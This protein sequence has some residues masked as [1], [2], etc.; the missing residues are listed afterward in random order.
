MRLY[1]HPGSASSRKVLTLLAEKGASCELVV[2]D[3]ASGQQTSDAFRKLHPFGKIPVLEH[4]GIVLYETRAIL[5]YL[6]QA[7]GGPALLP[8]APTARAQA[9]QWISIE[10]SYFGSATLTLL[11]Q[12][13]LGPMMGQEPEFNVV[14]E[15]RKT[16]GHALDVMDQTLSTR[17]YLA[18]SDFTMGDICMMPGIQVIANA[19]QGDLLDSR[20]S[21]VRWWD[22]VSQRDSWRSVL[23]RV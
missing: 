22:A 9:E 6:D 1:G 21:V 15:A 19:K 23:A 12:C 4:D 5:G 13:I 11:Y 10:T 3:L 7:L 8:E 14:N 16:L 17:A 18:G 20:P 2:I